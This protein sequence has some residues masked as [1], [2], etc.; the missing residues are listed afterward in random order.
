MTQSGDAGLARKKKKYIFLL[1]TTR[2]ADSPSIT[3]QLGYP[4]NWETN[5]SARKK[6]AR[7]GALIVRQPT[8]RPLPH[9]PPFCGTGAAWQGSGIESVVV[10]EI[11]SMQVLSLRDGK[12]LLR[13]FFPGRSWLS[14]L[15]KTLRNKTCGWNVPRIMK[16]TDHVI[17][18]HIYVSRSRYENYFRARINSRRSIQYAEHNRS[19][20][21]KL[22]D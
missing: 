12:V 2:M 13:I 1:D 9:S 5:C 11:S 17:R 3:Q 22:V 20:V 14:G 6:V 10:V 7:W 8:N 21:F 18:L 16:R 15:R 4:I 19:Y